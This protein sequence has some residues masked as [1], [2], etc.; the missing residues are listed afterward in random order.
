M[1]REWFAGAH[2]L[3]P[4]GVQQPEGDQK[5][6]CAVLARRHHSALVL[7]DPKFETPL[8]HYSKMVSFYRLLRF[9]LMALLRRSAPYIKV[10]V[11]RFGLRI[12]GTSSA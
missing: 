7:D 12:S 3:Y 8:S 11:G 2:A 5:G 6:A 4:I 9:V 10:V 1:G